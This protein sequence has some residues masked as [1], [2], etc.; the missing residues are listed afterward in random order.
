MTERALLEM[1]LA[2]GPAASVK[3]EADV[4]GAV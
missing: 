3:V 1:V 4:D 2:S